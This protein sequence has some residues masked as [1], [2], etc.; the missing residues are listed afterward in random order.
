MRRLTARGGKVGSIWWSGDNM[1]V[2]HA[3]FLAVALI[4]GLLAGCAGAAGSSGSPPATPHGTARPSATGAVQAVVVN[5]QDAYQHANWAGV[6]SQFTDPTLASK[7]IRT[8]RSWRESR[9]Q[10][11]HI[12]TVYSHR[13]ASGDY[14]ET[15]EFA[16][17]PRAVPAY[18]IYVVRFGRSPRIVGTTTGLLG[19]TFRDANWTVTRSQH[20]VFYHSPYQVAGSDRTIIGDL[21]YQRAQFI[22]QFGVKLPPL[23]NYFLYPTSDTMSQLTRHTSQPCGLRPENVGCANP[24]VNPPT[25]HTSIWPTYHEPIHIYQLAL[26]PGE[27]RGGMVYVAPLFIAEGMA[28]ALEDRTLDPRLSD[29]CS[30]LQYAPLDACARIAIAHAKPVD[31]LSDTGFGATDPGYAYSLGGSF[32]KFLILHYGYHP[33]GR[34][35]YVLAAQPKDR[36]SDYDV[37][38]QTVY[39]QS[40]QRLLNAFQTSLCSSGC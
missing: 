25:I 36:V 13:L 3:R 2:P 21:E 31:L 4:V 29:Y 15:L 14:V 11:L 23:A 40:I 34:F 27:R 16:G 39:H 32:V 6:R 24:F 1:G 38:S 10:N 8:M 33:F 35:Y 12:R 5:L 7:L 26:E 20:F 30:N 28:V 19:S 17:D 22:R 18:I 37:A 9:V